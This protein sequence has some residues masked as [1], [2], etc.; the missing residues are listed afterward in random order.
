MPI[1][2]NKILPRIVNTSDGRS[3]E[4][5]RE[6]ATYTARQSR[7]TGLKRWKWAMKQLTRAALSED[8][9]DLEAAVGAFQNAV[10]IDGMRQW[11]GTKQP[12][13]AL[14]QPR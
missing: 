10:L 5:L 14:G 7:R 3:I 12:S 2:W 8:S 6:A 11:S 9:A 13:P 4:T 1:N